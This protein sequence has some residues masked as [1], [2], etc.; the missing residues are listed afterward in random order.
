MKSKVNEEDRPLK[1]STF[2]VPEFSPG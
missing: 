1:G 2:K